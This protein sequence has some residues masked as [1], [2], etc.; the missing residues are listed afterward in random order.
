MELFVVIVSKR[1]VSAFDLGD[2]F[3]SS[4]ETVTIEGIDFNIPAG[5]KEDSKSTFNMIE[6]YIDEGY[7]FDGKVYAKDNTQ[8]GIYVY[9]YSS[10]DADDILG[11]FSNET[12]INDVGGFMEFDDDNYVFVYS[13]DKCIVMIASND[14]NVI[15]D[16]IIAWLSYFKAFN[17]IDEMTYLQN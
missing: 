2:I 14:K 1:A 5:Y 15:G 4:D 16:F 7:D 6:E 13:K 10:L 17:Y 3:G 12:T 8:V 9:N 11:D